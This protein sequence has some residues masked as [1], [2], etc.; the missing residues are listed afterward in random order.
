MENI[1]EQVCG[2]V[3]SKKN[4]LVRAHQLSELHNGLGDMSDAFDNL[5]YERLGMSCEDIADML[6]LGNI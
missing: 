3:M 4:R 1:Y 5:M 6:R 2:I